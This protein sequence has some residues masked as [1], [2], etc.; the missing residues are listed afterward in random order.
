[1]WLIPVFLL[2]LAVVVIVLY[3]GLVKLREE[4]DAAWSD[5]DVQLTRRHDLVP[6]L[7]ETVKGYAAHE[8]DVME[9]VVEARADA[10]DASGP[11]RQGEAEKS[12]SGALRSLFALAEDYPDL[13]ANRSFLELQSELS[14]LEDHIQR[15]RRY[16]NAVT[17]D[18]NTRVRQVPTNLVAVMFRFPGREFFAAEEGARAVPGVKLDN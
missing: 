5:I 16:Y 8:Q 12:L 4:A 2:A 7:V 10:L 3:N 9:R 18:Y 14:D 13:K 1:M 17:R 6:N 11:E 15:A